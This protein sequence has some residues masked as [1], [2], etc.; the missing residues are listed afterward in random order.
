MYTTKIERTISTDAGRID[1]TLFEVT[2]T[3]ASWFEVRVRDHRPH[4]H[5]TDVGEWLTIRTYADETAAR[6]GFEEWFALETTWA[7][8]PYT[9]TDGSTNS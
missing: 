4:L 8:N 9:P 5:R 6:A 1:V 3:R 7:A 2:G